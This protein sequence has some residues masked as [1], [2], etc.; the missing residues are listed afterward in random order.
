MQPLAVGVYHKNMG[1]N[2]IPNDLSI[3]R[4]WEKRVASKIK[5]IYSNFDHECYL[6]VQPRIKHLNPDFILVDA[7]KGITII[8]VKDWSRDYLAKVHNTHIIDVAGKRHDNPLVQTNQYFNFL[9]NI[10]QSSQSFFDKDGNFELLIHSRLVFPNMHVRDMDDIFQAFSQP[11]TECITSEQLRTLTHERLFSQNTRFLDKNAI[12][13]IRGMIFPEIKIKPVQTKLWTFNRKNGSRNPIIST[14]DG[15]QEKFARK[16]PYGHYMVT[17]V[18]GSG[19]T[20]ILLSRAIHLLKEKPNWKIRILTYNKPLASRLNKRFESMHEDLE[21]M[22]INCQNITISTFH[23]LAI[24]LST[25]PP[26]FTKNQDYWNYQLPYDSMQNAVEMYDAVLIDEYQDFLDLWV[27]LCLKVCKKHEYNDI[28]SENLFLAGDRLQS[29]YNSREHVWKNIGVNIVGRSKLLKTSY[30]SGSNHINLALDYLM[31]DEKLKKEIENFYEG[32]DGVYCVSDSGNSIDFIKGDMGSVNKYLKDLF[33]DEKSNPEDVVIL[34]TKADNSNA[35]FKQLDDELKLISYCGKDVQPNKINI[36]TYHLSKGLEYKVCVLINVDNVKDKKVL[37]VGMTRASEKLCIHSFSQDGGEI[38]NELLS[39]YNRMMT[40]VETEI[41]T[42]E[43]LTCDFIEE[44][45]TK[46]KSFY[47]TEIQKEFPNAYTPWSNKE[48]LKLIEL[49]EAG[50]GIEEISEAI[51][52]QPGGVRARLKRLG[53][54][55]NTNEK[56]VDKP[57]SLTSD[58]NDEVIDESKDEN[59]DP[60]SGIDTNEF[61]PIDEQV[62]PVIST[63]KKSFKWGLMNKIKKLT[64]FISKDEVS[65]DSTIQVD[66]NKEIDNPITPEI[67]KDEVSVDSTIQVDENKEIDNPIILESSK[68]WVYAAASILEKNGS[69]KLNKTA[70]RTHS[71][72]KSGHDIHE[73]ADIRGLKVGTIATYLISLAITGKEIPYSIIGKEISYDDQ[74]RI[75]EEL[76]KNGFLL[77]MQTKKTLGEEITYHHINLVIALLISY[78]KTKFSK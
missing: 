5:S 26:Q 57:C 33:V 16:I 56:V 63:P 48:E 66:D 7:Y 27:Q 2:V 10:L 42:N 41:L 40:P 14:L 58:E 37:Y 15:E 46:K 61:S 29:I 23:S 55:H 73:I 71:L 34:V 74:K 30:R 75:I 8:E 64:S 47:A 52:R 76:K 9:K 72:L 35:I 51:G 31:S 78:N 39:C 4:P 38:F 19:K 20:V 44:S 21:L 68:E 6:Y 17:G 43:T 13:T 25:A 28:V 49:Y 65:V 32:R 62:K 18:P 69:Y 60:K 77:K 22:G 24:E 1:L 59:Q 50:M 54:L 36:T 67:S 12:S 45:T 11:P 70:E 53:I 3:L